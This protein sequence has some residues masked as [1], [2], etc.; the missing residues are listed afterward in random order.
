MLRSA[1]KL[2]IIVYQIQELGIFLWNDG[3]RLF[4]SIEG[5]ALESTLQ[6]REW[7]TF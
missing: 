6:S 1:H 3:T 5:L 2:S 7:Y 4:S